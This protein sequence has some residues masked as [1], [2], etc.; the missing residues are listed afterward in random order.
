MFID[1]HL[2][3][4]PALLPFLNNIPCIANAECPEEYHWLTL[5]KLP[6]MKI[7]AGVH[8]WKAATTSW[9]EME[10]ILHT[11][12]IIGEIGLDG[13]WCDTDIRVQREIFHRQ[14][15]LAHRLK[16]PVILHTKGMEKEIL[17]TIRRYPN[18]YLVHWYS[19]EY[20]LEEYMELGCW[21]SVGPDVSSNP[22]VSKLANIVPLNRLLMESD[23]LEGMIWGQGIP[24]NPPDYSKIMKQH[25]QTLA[26]LRNIP[27]Q[28]LTTQMAKNLTS[29]IL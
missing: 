5:N 20:F 21:F 10:S 15:A 25:L 13:I 19:C 11:C 8:P 28:Q 4:T 26:L 9:N 1:A 7:S 16:K 18:R 3:V 29:F 27:P 23:G 17:H 2:H 12:T 22:H 24:V 14:L 6:L